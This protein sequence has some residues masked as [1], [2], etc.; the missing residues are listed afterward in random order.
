MS[1]SQQNKIVDIQTQKILDS[2]GDMLGGAANSFRCH[3][4]LFW[5]IAHLYFSHTLLQEHPCKILFTYGFPAP[6]ILK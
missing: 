5:F 1:A 3:T 2:T 4:Y 6:I